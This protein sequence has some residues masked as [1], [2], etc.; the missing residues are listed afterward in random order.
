MKSILGK[1]ASIAT[2]AILGG[3]LILA[4][5]PLYRVYRVLIPALNNSRALL[6]AGKDE[7]AIH[8]MERLDTW[9]RDYPALYCESA[10]LQTRGWTHLKR[11]KLAKTVVTNTLAY[12]EPSAST[13]SKSIKDW[14]QTPAIAMANQDM[15]TRYGHP[16]VATIHDILEG[17]M[18]ATPSETSQDADTNGDNEGATQD[19]ATTTTVNES[20]AEADSKLA[21]EPEAIFIPDTFPAWAAIKTSD[22]L[23]RNKTGKAT[24]KI[25]A[26]ALLT[27]SGPPLVRAKLSIYPCTQTRSNSVSISIYV[28]EKD[29]DFH[30]G[31]VTAVKLATRQLAVKRARILAAIYKID[32]LAEAVNPY[33][34]LLAKL[35]KDRAALKKKV[36]IL[37]AKRDNAT[38]GQRVDASDELHLLRDQLAALDRKEKTLRDSMAEWETTKHASTLHDSQREELVEALGT[39]DDK[40]S[41]AMSCP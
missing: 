23:V 4:A 14:I 39:I 40:L 26:G 34:Q 11:A 31:N 30:P 13:R 41:E 24:A 2:M 32:H 38:E 12:L 10:R 7:E 19:V 28:A 5:M 25:Q 21:D 37:T 20:Q 3:V 22:A 27:V 33:S 1:F 35:Q 29:L 8:A 16:S 9:V 6:D 18:G 17:E 15:E 36:P